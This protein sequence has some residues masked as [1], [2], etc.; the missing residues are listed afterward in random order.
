[1][2]QG[3]EIILARMDSHPEEFIDDVRK[4]WRW[5]TNQ[6]EGPAVGGLYFLTGEEKTALQ[7]KYIELVREQFT[8]NIIQQLLKDKDEG[9][10]P[11]VYSSGTGST[12]SSY[13]NIY[14]TPLTTPT[15]YYSRATTPTDEVRTQKERPRPESVW[16][17]LLGAQRSK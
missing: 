15:P 1:M 6:L 14:S 2:N 3:V 10:K 7:E 17:K 12:V 4:E 9:E 13:S 16:T 11:K 8:K 5:L